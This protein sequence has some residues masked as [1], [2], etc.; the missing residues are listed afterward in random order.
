LGF[1]LVKNTPPTP[2]MRP[3]GSALAGG[4]ESVAAASA[5]QA[6]TVRNVIGGS[7]GLTPGGGAERFRFMTVLKRNIW[8]RFLKAARASAL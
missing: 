4:I 2:V 5:A 7:P 3:G 1:L 6:R 8:P